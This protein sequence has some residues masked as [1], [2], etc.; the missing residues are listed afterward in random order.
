MADK[1]ILKRLALTD[2]VVKALDELH[3]RR[4]S[5][6]P[7]DPT[8]SSSI[9]GFRK[10]LYPIREGLKAA[11]EKYIRGV[12]VF[13]DMNVYLCPFWQANP[14]GPVLKDYLW[15]VVAPKH[16]KTDGRIQMTFSPQGYIYTQYVAIRITDSSKRF[17]IQRLNRWFRK[18]EFIRRFRK[19][20]LKLPY[21]FEM[22]FTPGSNSGTRLGGEVHEIT[23]AEWRALRQHGLDTDTYFFVARYHKRDKLRDLTVDELGRLLVADLAELSGIYPILQGHK[24]S[25]ATKRKLPLPDKVRRAR[26]RTMPALSAVFKPEFSGKKK[27]YRIDGAIDNAAGHGRIVNA[28]QAELS[29]RG[30]EAVNDKARDLFVQNDDEGIDTLFEIKTNTKTTSL[31]QAIGQLMLH[32]AAEEEEPRRIAVLPQIPNQRTLA[33]IERMGIAVL[34][35]RVKGKAVV[36]ENLDEIIPSKFGGEVRGQS[37]M[38]RR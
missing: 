4:T 23:A 1:D 36:F 30:L 28:L 26:H 22:W 37:T 21:G 20:L 12:P 13:A 16:S 19:E 15:N 32:G 25:H 2:R 6:T 31:Y 29:A 24:G 3:E 9:P 17:H 35:F 5:K 8:G 7:A 18:A 33:A 38:A 27:S 14:I 11:Q 10:R 34:T